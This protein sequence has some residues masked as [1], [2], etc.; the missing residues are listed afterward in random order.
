MR[1]MMSLCAFA[2]V[3]VC[4]AS[5]QASVIATYALHDHPD[6]NANPPSYGLRMDGLFGGGVTTFSMDHFGDTTLQVFEE[7]G[8]FSIIIQGTLFGGETDGAGG[9]LDGKAYDV[10]FEY[11][12]GVSGTATGWDVQGAS[13]ASNTGSLTEQGGSPT[14][15][16]T[17]TDSDDNSFIF[18]HDGHRLAGDDSTAVGRGWLTT[19]SNGAPIGGTQDWL[20]TAEMIPAPGG[21]VLFALVAGFGRRR[22]R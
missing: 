16:F 18:Q 6:G 1:N 15:L 8:L 21:A 13:L 4:T 3:C 10:Y 2:S 14:D 9:Y 19:N 20:F 17:I 5:L 11:T 22:R 7:G 12:Q